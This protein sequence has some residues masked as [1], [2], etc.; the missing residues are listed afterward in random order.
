MAA[1]LEAKRTTKN[2]RILSHLV[3]L[4][5]GIFLGRSSI[6]YQTTASFTTTSESIRESYQALTV[7]GTAIKALVPMKK[8]LPVD[9]SL[10]PEIAPVNLARMHSSHVSK[11]YLVSYSWWDSRLRSPK[12]KK[13]GRNATLRGNSAVHMIQ[14]LLMKTPPSHA[15]VDVG[16]NVGF[17]TNFAARDRTVY[18]IDP[19]SYDISKI[20]EANRANLAQ[21]WATPNA[22][23]LFH[24]AAGPMEKPNITITR[25]PDEVGYFDQSS[26]S[27]DAVNQAKIVEEV[28]PM[29]TV[30]SIV[31]DD[32]PISVVKIDVQGHEYGVLQG[33]TKVL[34]RTTGYPLYVYYEELEMLLEQTGGGIAEGGCAKLLEPYGYNCTKTVHDVLCSKP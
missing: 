27:R 26:L 29:V 4:A 20:C 28:I 23:H 22:L 8:V 21:G 31:P 18:A 13:V 32:V 30:D 7:S 19:I 10:I 24:A 1:K 9:C 2:L 3:T 12:Y 15:F 11:P 5:I 6:S 34:G 16:A 25:P 33:M 17:M 14:D